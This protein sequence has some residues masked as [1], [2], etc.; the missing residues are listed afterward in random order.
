MPIF[1]AFVRALRDLAHPRVL[2][3]LFLP[4]LG[5]IVLWSV[6]GFVF[7]DAWT[8][9]LQ[10]AIDGTAA[11]RWLVA[12]G[13]GW[14][15][16]SAAGLSVF[17][18]L[19]PA[20][21]ITAVLITELVAMPMIVSVVERTYPALAKRGGGTV[22][23]SLGNATAAVLVFTVLWLLTLPLW[24]T[25]IGAVVLPVLNSAYL[26]QRLFRYDALSEHATR[27][28]YREI[29]RRAKGRLYALGV[30]LGVLYYVPLVN[31][32]APVVSGLAFTHFC[33][34]ELARVRREAGG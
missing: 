13:A 26:N 7:W 24:L 19:L 6:L 17:G 3:I 29:V 2:A 22:L 16:T 28:E 10:A 5:A 31:L 12:H 1:T 8:G 11:G 9:W 21:L 4:M 18:L 20:V 33:L 14:V 34:G 30:I 32:A 27:D 25:G 15:L 23:G